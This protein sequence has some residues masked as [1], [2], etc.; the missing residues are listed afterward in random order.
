MDEHDVLDGI[1]IVG[2]AGRFPGAPDVDTFWANL[3]NGV[4]SV[5]PATDAELQAAGVDTSEP[6]FVNAGAAMDGIEEFDAEYFGMN[7]R[8]AEV[9]DPQHRVLIETVCATL[10]HA[11]YD[12]GRTDARIGVFGGVAPNMYLRNNLLAHPQ[13]LARYGATALLLATEREYAITRVAYK[14]GLT[15]PAVSLSTACSTSAVAAHVATNS[16][17]SGECD[18]ALAGGVNIKLPMA[19]GYIYQ[20]DGILSA[21]GHVRAFDADARGTVM[22]SGAA[23]VALKR[24]ADALEDA[25]TVYAVIRG[26]AINNDGATKVGF[27]A[28]SID[29]QTAVIEE[30]LGVADVDAGTIG[31]VEAHGTGTSVG[32]PV[33]V[34]ALTR[35]Y[36][37][38]TTRRQYCALGSLKSNIGHLD[39]AAGAAGIIKVAL[40][41]YHRR[42]PP[43]IN[44]DSANPQI[45]FDA[46][47]FFVDTELRD[48]A[49]SEEPRRA[50]ISSFGFGGTNAHLVLEEA[51]QPATVPDVSPAP[52]RI[53]TLSARTPA[54]LDQRVHDLADHLDSEEGPDLA[55]TAYTLAVGRSPMPYRA[56]VV[57]GEVA[58]AVELLRDAEPDAT[59]PRSSGV[60]GGTVGFLF[61]GQ[62]AQYPGMGVELYRAEPV[63]A[64]AIEE[65]ARIVGD[66]DGHD[67]ID[68]L[69]G[70]HADPAAAAQRLMQTVVGQPVIFALQYALSRL[71]SSWGVV[72]AAMVGHSVGELAAACIGGVFTLEAAVRVTVAR[73]RLMQELATGAMTAILADE[74]DVVPLLD[75]QTSLAAVNAPEQIVASGQPAS[76]DE[77]ERQ[78]SAKGISFRRL[79]TDRAFHSPM[80]DS[81]IDALQDEIAN[82]PRAGLGIP[83]VSTVTGTWAGASELSDPTYWGRHARRTV[84][85]VDAISVLLSERPGLFLVEIGPGDTL[86]SLVRQRSDG[87]PEDLLASTLP[88]H[89]AATNDAIHARRALADA[90]MAGADIDL[91]AANGGRARRVALPTYP[92][93]RV[94]HWVEGDAQA[95]QVSPASLALADRTQIPIATTRPKPAVANGADRPDVASRRDH[96]ATQLITIL[97]D[98]SGLDREAIDPTATFIDLGFDSLF[99]TQANSEFRKQFGVRCT[100]GQLFDETPS[101]NAL[102]QR[103]DA[104][105]APHASG[106]EVGPARDAEG[107][108]GPPPGG[109]AA[110]PPGVLSSGSVSDHAA[111]DR[112]EPLITQQLALMERQLD[113]MRSRVIAADEATAPTRR[114]EVDPATVAL[115]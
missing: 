2:M 70:E 95:N 14:L 92:F 42:I 36:R 67:L 45:D 26:S 13:M 27:T 28:P 108:R 115:E 50:A 34:A 61:T 32:D 11:G 6:G 88:R 43:S 39:A 96:I 48:W 23:F 21:N 75:G 90:W 72:P 63:F 8:E 46:S 105:V 100:L 97:V 30:A 79:P 77:L 7:K 94:R 10:E 107:F 80:M 53:L 87:P 99:L 47:P 15:G 78:L 16:L 113:L 5:R 38:Y 98:L 20:E 84:R 89:G 58:S 74:A 35:A 59:A 12:P 56:A 4:E 102:A 1:A 49:P 37:Q 54:A 19:A 111:A 104:E 93:A 44:F 65:C 66:L 82:V 91:M 81:V 33:E 3:S 24:L 29:G 71:W 52:Y 25:D 68:L 69:Y 114:P 40:S 31:M 18:M 103:I 17:L 51:P 85:F 101:V 60:A 112:L 62:G 73:G 64:S 41:L 22:A 57:A 55:D 110:E 109:H 106:V 76:I 86:G 83:M 9:T